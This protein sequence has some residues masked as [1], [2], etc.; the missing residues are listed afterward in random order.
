MRNVLQNCDGPPERDRIEHLE[1]QMFD[2]VRSSPCIRVVCDEGSEW[3]TVPAQHPQPARCGVTERLVEL[4]ES[5]PIRKDE[6]QTQ[7]GEIR[8]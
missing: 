7:E 2:T 3:S 6:V 4:T 1:A 8:S 5:A